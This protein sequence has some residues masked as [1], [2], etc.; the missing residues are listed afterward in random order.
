MYSERNEELRQIFLEAKQSYSENDLVY[1]DESGVDHQIIK[2]TCWCKKGDNIIG[3]RSG[4]K[5]GRT[6]VIAALNGENINAP[7]CFEGTANTNLFLY[8]VENLLLH[9]LKKVRSLSW[10][11]VQFI[12]HLKYLN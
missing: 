9:T 1:I 6:S 12:N 8:W 4:G 7:F 11:I 10:T 2:D 5:R 3:E